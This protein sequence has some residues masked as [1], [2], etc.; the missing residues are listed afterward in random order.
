MKLL[1]LSLL[2]LNKNNIQSILQSKSITSIIRNRV[3]YN[4]AL[5]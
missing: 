1:S 5:S 3:P 2:D 4:K